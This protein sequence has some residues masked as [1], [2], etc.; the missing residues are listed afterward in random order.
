MEAATLVLSTITSSTY[1]GDSDQSVGICPKSIC[2]P[3][4]FVLCDSSYLARK[5]GSILGSSLPFIFTSNFPL[6]SRSLSHLFSYVML[7]SSLQQP[8]SGA[9]FSLILYCSDSL[10]SVLPTTLVPSITF[11]VTLPAGWLD[12]ITFLI[13]NLH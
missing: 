1:S 6:R 3:P 4:V 9:H 12:H 11:Q 10:L 7:Q 13:K 8:W 2:L 5:H